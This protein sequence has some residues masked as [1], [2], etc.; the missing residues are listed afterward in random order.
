MT[1]G[2]TDI[3]CAVLTSGAFD[4]MERD[5]R[6]AMARG[7]PPPSMSALK[8]KA[9]YDPLYH[10]DGIR[11]DTERRIYVLGHPLDTVTPFDLQ[12]KFADAVTAAGHH[13][14]LRETS[15]KAPNYHNLL[16][17]AGLKTAKRCAR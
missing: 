15:A 2:R 5:R 14:E 13:A 3:H 10:I 4:L 12:K 9:Y 17:S 11:P 16:G 8:R 1:L 6:R 7:K